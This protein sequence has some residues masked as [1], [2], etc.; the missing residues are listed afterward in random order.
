MIRFQPITRD[1]TKAMR[2]Q[3]LPNPTVASEPPSRD[4]ATVLFYFDHIAPFHLAN[5]LHVLIY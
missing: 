2:D 5:C 1:E 3:I 4:D